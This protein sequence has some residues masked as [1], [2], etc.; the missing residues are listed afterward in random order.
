MQNILWQFNS[1]VYIVIF[2]LQQ[3]QQIIIFFWNDTEKLNY[4]RKWN[5]LKKTH[6]SCKKDVAKCGS[7]AQD[8]QGEKLVNQGC[9][10]EMAVMVDLCKNL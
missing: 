8:V 6:S 4:K 2:S 10:Q 7:P 5:L 1:V 9:S 3:I